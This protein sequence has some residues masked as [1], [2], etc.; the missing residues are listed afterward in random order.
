MARSDNLAVVVDDKVPSIVS[1]LGAGFSVGSGLTLTEW[2]V[3]VGI[4]T[5]LLTFIANMVYQVRREKREQ[6]QHELLI[7]QMS[8]RVRSDACEGDEP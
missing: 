6:Q 2:G 7:R 5:A 3:V 8:R 1:Y 4:L